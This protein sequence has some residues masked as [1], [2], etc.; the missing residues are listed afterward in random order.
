MCREFNL[1]PVT[2]ILSISQLSIK[3]I[4]LRCA[5]M[6]MFVAFGLVADNKKIIYFIYEL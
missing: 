1:Q 6:L 3:A 4:A 2:V 5:A